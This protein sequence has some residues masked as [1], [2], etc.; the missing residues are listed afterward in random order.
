MIS[1]QKAGTFTLYSGTIDMTTSNPQYTL[2]DVNGGTFNMH[3]GV[4][5][6]A[7]TKR[8][9]GNCIQTRNAGTINVTGGT[10]YGDVILQHAA[11]TLN[12]AADA[13][14]G[15]SLTG[16][17]SNGITAWVNGTKV[18]GTNLTSNAQIVFNSGANVTLSATGAKEAFIVP[19]DYEIYDNNGTWSMRQK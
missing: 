7:Q 18:N 5:K 12:V 13:K 17:S 8:A 16:I 1:Y 11:G 4:M 2:I 15:L 6:G 9:N 3:G 14:V 19:S 10:I